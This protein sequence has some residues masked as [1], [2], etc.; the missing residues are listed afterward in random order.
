MGRIKDAVNCRGK[1]VRSVVSHVDDI[2]DDGRIVPLFPGFQSDGV[3][4]RYVSLPGCIL[5]VPAVPVVPLEIGFKGEADVDKTSVNGR[6]KSTL[7]GKHGEGGQLR[8]PCGGGIFQ[9]AV[10][11]GYLAAV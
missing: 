4:R 10:G 5:R 11:D 8:F 2:T 6:E 1:V 7:P 9:L 3:G